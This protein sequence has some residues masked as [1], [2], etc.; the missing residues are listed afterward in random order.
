[1]AIEICSLS[2]NAQVPLKKRGWER[3]RSKGDLGIVNPIGT[4]LSAVM[5]SQHL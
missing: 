1:M 5:S 2:A 4:S 3:T